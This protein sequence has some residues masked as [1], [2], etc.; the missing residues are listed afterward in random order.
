MCALLVAP[1]DAFVAVQLVAAMH[2]YEPGKVKYM[3]R[4]RNQQGRH[5]SKHDVAGFAR[6]VETAIA[7]RR[8]EALMQRARR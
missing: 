2:K 1:K 8:F 4:M 5:A 7:E 6:D 3:D